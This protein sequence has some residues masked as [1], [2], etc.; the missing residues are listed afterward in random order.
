MSRLPAR[1][2]V[3]LRVV[4]EKREM[5]D[6]SSPE[7]SPPEADE[8]PTDKGFLV[9]LTRGT[10]PSLEPFAGRV[11]HLA[12]GRRLRFENFADFRAAVKRLLP[13]AKQP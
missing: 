3:K 2:S 7:A 11:E 4:K 1:G 10:G 8:L 9:Q 6:K 13:L 12:S 5:P